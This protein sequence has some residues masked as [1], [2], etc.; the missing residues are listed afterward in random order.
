VAVIPITLFTIVYSETFE[1]R[2]LNNMS[3]TKKIEQEI[4]EIIANNGMSFIEA[5]LL[6]TG[7]ADD[8][9]AEIHGVVA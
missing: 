3:A 9:N 7:M 8:I 5:W 2:R 1:T 6:L 4:Y